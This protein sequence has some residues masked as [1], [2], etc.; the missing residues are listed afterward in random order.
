MAL[1]RISRLAVVVLAAT[2]A[3]AVAQDEDIAPEKASSP[4]VALIFTPPPDLDGRI[5]LG[6]FD[7]AGKLRRTLAFEQGS[8]DLK[9]D[10]N[11]YIAQW[12]GCDSAGKPCAAGRYSARGFVVSED[13]SVEGMEFD[14]NDWMAED[15]IPALGVE[16]R[17]WPDG[18]G[19]ELKTATGSVFRRIEADGRLV[20]TLPPASPENI[21][22]APAGAAPG[23]DGTTWMILSLEGNH[24]VF[25]LDKDNVALRELRVPADEPQPV[26][27]LAA[28]TG[29]AI[30]LKES[31]ADDLVRVRML[32]R[33]KSG[34]E[35]DGRVV[36]DWEV[37]F[38]RTLQPC[39]KFGLVGGELVADAG[40][41]PQSDSIEFP[42]V[43]NSLSPMRQQLRLVAVATKP[44]SAL[45]TSDGLELIE[46]SAA[47]GW[48]RF[49]LTGDGHNA[50]LY[51]GD[52]VVVE[53]FAIRNLDHIAKFDAGSFLLAAPATQ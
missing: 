45:T 52:G 12:D 10:T 16:L 14:F 8:P 44:G 39:A 24:A 22:G 43:A 21:A 4:P 47:D 29:D 1:L 6:I 40:V 25:Q 46:V 50:A 7:A 13:V 27:V 48:N 17:Q 35:K 5:V 31:G 23:S 19:V 3:A 41:A 9:I 28:P 42:L 51:Q 32:R 36:A 33:G 18:I 38:E 26:A 30:L 53:E 34:A 15:R 2:L 11:G 49:A 37:V 20:E